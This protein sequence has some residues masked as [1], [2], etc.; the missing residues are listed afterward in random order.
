M[1]RSFS[2]FSTAGKIAAVAIGFC[3]SILGLMCLFIMQHFLQEGLYTQNEWNYYATE[4]AH[5][6]TSA[7]A[8]YVAEVWYPHLLEKETLLAKEETSGLSEEE[9]SHLKM[10]TEMVRLDEVKYH[11]LSTSL[12]FLLMSNGVVVD[13]GF[14]GG[15]GLLEGERAGMFQ[16]YS[17]R[18][19]HPMTGEV[20]DVSVDCYVTDP[21]VAGDAYARDADLLK[22]LYEY[23]EETIYLLAGSLALVIAATVY[24]LFAAG[25]KR[26]ENGLEVVQGGLH[27]IPMDILAVAIS[28]LVLTLYFRARSLIGESQQLGESQAASLMWMYRNVMASLLLACIWGLL[29]F[30][31]MSVVIRVRRRSLSERSVLAQFAQNA[32]VQMTQLYDNRTMVGRNILLIVG[33]A[34]LTALLGVWIVRPT[35]W[36]I[37]I[38]YVLFIL[39]IAV[40]VINANQRHQK[41]MQANIHRMAEG[42]LGTHIN[43]EGMTGAV[44]MEAEELNR[45]NDAVQEAVNARLQ[46]ERMK[47]ELLTNVTHDIKTPLTN[48]IN[49]VDLLKRSDGLD[50]NELSAEQRDYLAVLESQS[51]RMKKLIE[52]LIEATKAST[53]NITIHQTV[54]DL[55]EMLEQAVGEYGDRLKSKELAVKTS[56]PEGELYVVADGE[57]LWRVLDN[58]LSNVEKYALPGTEVEIRAE[59]VEEDTIVDP[60]IGKETP[61]SSQA[62]EITIENTSKAP[63]KKSGEELIERFVRGDASRH[64]EGSGLGLAI[65]KSL[66]E[67]MGGQFSIDVKA[68]I[69][70][71]SIKLLSA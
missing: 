25:K 46:S 64:S 69:F 53:G 24:L 2:I 56:L 63:I 50:G 38:V 19:N 12:R 6:I 43:T 33:L 67:L 20:M 17:F 55:K 62:V 58:I 42:E 26:T 54:L 59:A 45:I 32:V 9:A 27:L 68:A 30:A 5:T 65:A 49:Y 3:A 18:V 70:T 37:L 39:V 48:I 66:T 13:S 29:V 35:Y 4:E 71:V 11:P 16:S 41:R 60:F 36:W 7:A 15:K 51:I 10:I 57:Q 28:A 8:S 1:K 34:V 44:K 47:T 14:A 52:D 22:M 23:R 40:V 61:F 31:F 21:L